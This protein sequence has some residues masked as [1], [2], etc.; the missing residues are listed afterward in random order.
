MRLPLSTFG[1]G[2]CERY[3]LHEAAASL[4]REKKAVP[5]RQL[6]ANF[7]AVNDVVAYLQSGSVVQFV[8]D[9]YG[10]QAVRTL[11]RGGLA[12]AAAAT[13]LAPDDLDAAWRAYL[14]RPGFH[15]RPVN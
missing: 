4:L 9:T 14:Q 7:Y 10:I 2:H 5:L 3:T 13:G 1:A 11:W 15:P 6:A 8:H 12:Q